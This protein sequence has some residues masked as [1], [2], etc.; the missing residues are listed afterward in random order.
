MSTNVTFNGVVYSVPAAGETAWSSLAS[1]LLA[2]GNNAQTKTSMLSAIRV[3]TTTP[4]AVAAATDFTVVTKLTVP[5]AVSVV[6]P[7]GVSGQLFAIVDGTGDAD[8]NN[9]TISGTGGQLIA[10]ASTY[11]IA[12]A[13]GAALLQW[14]VTA[15]MWQVIA[16]IGG[17]SGIQNFI[18][19]T[20]T[21]TAINRDRILADTSGGA[22]TITLPASP[23]VG[24]AVEFYDPKDTWDTLN[25]TVARNGSL[26]HG[27]A[28]NLVLDV[29]GDRVLLVYTG[30]SQG[31]RA[32]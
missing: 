15:A 25:L 4:V 3:A 10:G 26:I 21:Y 22:F 31:W 14:S 23:S 7:A 2:L 20:T 19:K 17:T 5:A 30:S 9:I 29:E 6:L 27:A 1:L 13:R 16:D 18:T 32:Y 8:T 12:T 24:N 11:V 28:A